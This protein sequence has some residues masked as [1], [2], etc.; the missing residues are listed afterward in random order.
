MRPAMAEL[1]SATRPCYTTIRDSTV[2]QAQWLIEE[3]LERH[4]H[5]AARLSGSAT[6]G[7][8]EL[9]ITSLFH[10]G[11]MIGVRRP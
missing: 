2:V 4:P 6:T 3:I 9:T 5:A 7:A 10:K 1:T 11:L 8:R